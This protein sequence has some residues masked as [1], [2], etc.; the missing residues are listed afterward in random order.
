MKKEKQENTIIYNCI[1]RIKCLRIN[2]LRRIKT[3][4]E[5]YKTLMK[6]IGDDTNIWKDIVCVYI[7]IYIYIYELEEVI[8]LKYLYYPKESEDIIQCL[9]K[10][11]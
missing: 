4:F 7:Y 3:Y 6:E 2:L 1:K 8:L 9:S 10:Y 5:N 11:L